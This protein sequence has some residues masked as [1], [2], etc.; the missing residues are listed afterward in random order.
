M[1]STA[2]ILLLTWFYP[3]SFN[4]F[5]NLLIP[6]SFHSTL[7]RIISPPLIFY[8]NMDSKSRVPRPSVAPS[9]NLQPTET[10]LTR[11]D[12]LKRLFSSAFK[13]LP[14]GARGHVVAVLGEFIGT[15]VFIFLAFSGVEAGAASTNK[16]QGE[17]VSTGPSRLSPELLLYIATS[18]G[19]SLVV[20]TWVFFRI[21][22]GLFNPVVR[23]F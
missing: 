8:I 9:M 23:S 5:P 16:N 21:S 11:I 14:P 6:H 4:Y 13:V 19:F 3:N 18:V 10:T 2:I 7:E 12:P 15:L 22:G 1:H 17:G 20:T